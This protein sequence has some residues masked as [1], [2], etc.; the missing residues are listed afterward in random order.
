M[1]GSANEKPALLIIDMVKD[2]FK[3][4]GKLPITPWAKQI[5]P[6]INDLIDGFRKNKWPIVFSTDAFHRLDFI[7]RGKMKP[8]SLAGT[9][10]AEVIEQLNRKEED[11]WLPKPRFSAFF[12]TGLDWWLQDRDVTLCAVTGIATNFCVL[13][14]VLDSI[15][16]DFKTVLVEDCTAASS[17]KI[18]RQTLDNYRR[19]PIYPLLKVATSKELMRELTGKGSIGHG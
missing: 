4:S 16:Y 18:H 6:P 13:T 19:N 7:F 15:C 17:E 9:K 8:H 2:T 12:K 11:L 1:N 5:I 3:E 14:T 10:G